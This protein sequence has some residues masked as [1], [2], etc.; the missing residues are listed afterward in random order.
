MSGTPPPSSP[1]VGVLSPDTQTSL[2]PL[3]ALL[4]EV[5][6]SPTSGL[7]PPFAIP[8]SRRDAS[9]VTTR[10][11]Q[12]V[13]TQAPS[14]VGR[15][16]FVPI[17]F[18]PPASSAVGTRRRTREEWLEY[19]SDSQT[20]AVV[21]ASARPYSAVKS[22][23]PEEKLP[24]AVAGGASALPAVSDG[25]IRPALL[26]IP[27]RLPPSTAKAYLR[28]NR[29]LQD[30]I[31]LVGAD[32]CPRCC[33]MGNESCWADPARGMGGACFTCAKHKQKCGLV[34]LPPPLVAP[35]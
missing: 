33:R 32:R 31:G 26:D 12:A 2:P 1:T 8:G 7:P 3:S 16:G 5:P 21:T 35:Y 13:L 14:G 19:Q 10:S 24:A 6:I 18:P 28:A 4:R 23:S 9:V 30:A 20:G 29:I 27:A 15:R 11:P 22:L 34:S 17:N 25:P